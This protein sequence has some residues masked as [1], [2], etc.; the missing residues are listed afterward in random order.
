MAVEHGGAQPATARGRA[1]ATRDLV[2]VAVLAVVWGFLY[3]QWVPV[4]LAVAGLGAQVGQEALFGFWLAA[5]VLASYIIRRPGAVL[6]GELLAAL[7][8]VLFGSAAGTAL[9]ITGIMEGLGAEAVFA[10]RGWR[11]YSVPTCMLA[12]AVNAVVAL[13]W[14]WYRLGYFAL[15]HRFQLVLLVT[16][17]LS[18]AILGGLFPRLLGDALARTGVL[19][20]F[21]VGQT[22]AADA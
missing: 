16:R 3:L 9:L 11:D 19:A 2:V 7:A 22:P 10:A 20:S 18:G 4:W 12:G 21:P 8:E 5:G 15:D 1:W 6:V 13:P 14:N 17:V